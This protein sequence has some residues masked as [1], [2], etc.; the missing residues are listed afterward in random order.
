MKQRMVSEALILRE[1][2]QKMIRIESPI[3]LYGK[4]ELDFIHTLFTYIDGG[5]DF[6][7]LQCVSDGRSRMWTVDRGVE[8]LK[9]DCSKQ[10]DPNYLYSLYKKEEEESDL[11]KAKTAEIAE[12]KK[13]MK[14]FQSQFGEYFNPAE[15]II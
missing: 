12:L 14:W 6:G 1:A 3:A 7:G 10:T 4:R 8:V 13:K 15:K 11:I 9:Q 5:A 2:T